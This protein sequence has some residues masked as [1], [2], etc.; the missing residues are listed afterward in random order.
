MYVDMFTNHEQ[1]DISEHPLINALSIYRELEQ[2]GKQLVH[3][4][5]DIYSWIEPK[6][7]YNLGAKIIYLWFLL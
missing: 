3:G 6:T 1:S 5:I 7:N 2:G 4:R